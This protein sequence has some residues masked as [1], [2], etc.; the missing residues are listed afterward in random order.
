MFYRT[1]NLVVRV[2]GSGLAV[3]FGGATFILVSQIDFSFC[4]SCIAFAY[5]RMT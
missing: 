3:G 5:K 4:V 2:P 1:M